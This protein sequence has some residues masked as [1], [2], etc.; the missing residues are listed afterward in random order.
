[1][2]SAA[3]IVPAAPV[4]VPELAQG[5]RSELDGCRAAIGAALAQVLTPVPQLV[6]VVGAGDRTRRHESGTPGSLAC[7]G[8]DVAVR[9]GV[10]QADASTPPLPLSLTL[11]AWVLGR[12]GWSAQVTGLELA[13]D[14][15]PQVCLGAGAALADDPARIVLLVVADGTARRGPK[16][17][18]Y[19]DERALGFDERWVRAVAAGD[20]DVLA[21]IDPGEA[22]ELM[23]AG[24]APLQV[25][26]GA[27]RGLSFRADLLYR[28]DP[29]GVQYV[30]ATWRRGRG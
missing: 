19:T 2:L 9:L 3:A 8:V 21:T 29:Y 28:D 30:V 7:V 5:A 17:P 20:A 13:A 15:A 25:L 11:G 4:L 1:M 24:R 6:V 22:D 10:G 12:A 14:E 23:M 27:A 26:A 16:A 18:G